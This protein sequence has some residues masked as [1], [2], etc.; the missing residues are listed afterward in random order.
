MTEPNSFF[1]K[2]TPRINFLDVAAD[3][4]SDLSL[5]PLL[6]LH[7]V[8][9]S[10]RTW[11]ELRPHLRHRRIIAPDYRGHGAS[12]AS[13]PPYE[14]D[15]FVFD[16]VRLLDELRV[17]KVDVVGFSI[18]ALFAEQL[19]LTH[20][21]RVASIVLLSSI[22]ARTEEERAR[23]S[24]R[25]SVI[26]TTPP[27]ETAQLSA[28][29]WF[30]PEFRE[31]RPDLVAD[32]VRIVAGVQHRPYAATYRVLVENDPIDKVHAISCPTL[33]ITGEFDEGSTPRMSE[34]LHDTIPGSE[35]HI[36]RGSKHYAHIEAAADVAQLINEFLTANAQPIESA[37][38][39][40]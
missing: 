21:D 22:A 16:A 17:P 30:S 11:D 31:R 5:P 14:L 1:T 10:S 33:I 20:P 37:A 39:T 18:G 3:E 28:V 9:S 7:G 8:G 13:E 27:T 25:L 40:E 4:G 26:E 29:R 6:L 2:S 35:L 38:S 12:E 15:D 34:R 23:S 24:A 36:I 32:E 19:Q